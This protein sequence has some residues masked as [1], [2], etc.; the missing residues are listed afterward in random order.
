MGETLAVPMRLPPHL[1]TEVAF[2]SYPVGLSVEAIERL[3]PRGSPAFDAM[4]D[5]VTD[6]PPQ[7]AVANVLMINLLETILK[8]LEAAER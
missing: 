1:E 2:P 5:C 4:V 7:H 6:G 8:T 3:A